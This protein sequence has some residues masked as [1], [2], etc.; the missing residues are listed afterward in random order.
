MQSLQAIRAAT[1]G[2]GKSTKFYQALYFQV[3]VGVIAGI[4]LGHFAPDAGV[5]VK[6]LGDGFVKIVKMMIVP[7]VFCTIVIGIAGIGHDRSIGSTLLKSMALFYVLTAIALLVGLISVEALQPGTGLHID[8][9]AIDPTEAARYAKS[10]K[11]LDPVEMLLQVIPRSFFTPFAEGEVLPVLFIAII[12]G[13]GLR[14]IGVAGEALLRGLESFSKALFAAFSFLMKLAPLGAFGAIA[15]IVAKNGIRTV[16]NLGLLILTFYVACGVFVFGVLWL[17]ARINGFSLLKLL[18][19]VREE[20]LVVLGTA[21]TEPVL[22]A[23]LYK[24]ERLGCSK[25]SVGL[26]LPLGY[27]FNLDGTAIYLTLASLFLAQAMDVHLS[28]WQIMS[29]ILVMLLTSKGAAGVTGSGFAALVATLAA[30]PDTL[31][32]AGVVIIAGID[33]FMSEARAL[34]SLVSNAVACIAIAI[35]EG[36]CDLAR[37]HNE[38]DGSASAGPATIETPEIETEQPVFRPGVSASSI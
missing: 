13:F 36:Q 20:L 21:S 24:L 33:R 18:R 19:Y 8:V 29:M 15:F 37:L 31:P 23:L 32:V 30:M 3:L 34:T 27:S 11:T 35:W 26:T 12:T 2:R 5:L 1:D 16:G 22:P 4:L 28:N 17:L 9:H 25:G 10:A 38:L 7:V 14:R 6:P